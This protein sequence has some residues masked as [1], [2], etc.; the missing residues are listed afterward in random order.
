MAQ[1]GVYVRECGVDPNVACEVML[2]TSGREI[3][4]CWR[5]NS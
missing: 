1:F 5:A 2:T 3:L 4:L